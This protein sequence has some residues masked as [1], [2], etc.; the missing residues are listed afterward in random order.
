MTEPRWWSQ[1]FAPEGSAAAEGIANQ[2]GRPSLDPLEVLVREA[3]QNSWDARRND[4]KVQFNIDL[5]R[6]GDRSAEW[7]RQ[8][9][10]SRDEVDIHGLDG[11]LSP[12]STLLTVSDRGTVGLGGPGRAG[13][14]GDAGERSDFVQF[15]RNVGEPRDT[16]LGGGT[17]GFGKGIFYRL[18]HASAI[19]VDSRFGPSLEERRLM[20]AAVGRSYF[21]SGR[22]FTGRHWWGLVG[23]DNVPDPLTGPQASDLVTQLDLRGFHVQET[24]TD[25]VVLG[26]ELGTDQSG[27]PRSPRAAGEYLVSA[28]LWHLWPK[29]VGEA[30]ERMEF[31]VSVEGEPIPLPDPRRVAGLG[32]FVDALESVRLGNGDSFERTVAPRY[33]GQFDTAVGASSRSEGGIEALARPFELPSHHVARMRQAELVV[34]YFEGPTHPNP[35]LEYGGVFRASPD[36]DQHFAAAE[37]PTHDAWVERGLAGS[38]RGVVVGARTFLRRRLEERFGQTAGSGTA[39]AVGV[40]GFARRLGG[41]IEHLP[42][43]RPGDD[44]T[45]G[46][47]G[48]VNREGGA[49]APLPTGSGI[50]LTQPTKVVDGPDGPVFE[51][52]VALPAS[53]R[54]ATYQAEAQVRLEGGA[55]EMTSPAGAQ[56]PEVLKWERHGGEDTI[57]GAVLEWVWD[58]PTEWRISASFVPDAVVDIVVERVAR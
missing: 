48:T 57:P 21:R 14:Q 13:V 38:D 40:A 25:I 23:E 16:P 49:S 26:A 36:A 29:M 18:S 43:T 44:P 52:R 9:V 39:D 42:A 33:V 24:G 34:D 4:T 11:A 6:M 47:S 46:V 56:V 3:A 35:S 22:R 19:L 31:S 7:M 53:P 55:R 10:P 15:I 37:P 54:G 32:A 30:A 27:E 41:L 17:Y 58:V 8:F 20:G 12:D 50:R 45:E 28:I 2:L 1:P 5:R 51:K